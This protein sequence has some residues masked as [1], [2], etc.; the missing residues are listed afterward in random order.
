MV[1]LHDET[2]AR[3]EQ[4]DPEKFIGRVLYGALREKIKLSYTVICVYT[5]IMNSLP[6]AVS[7]RLEQSPPG[8]PSDVTRLR[9]LFKHMRACITDAHEIIQ[10]DVQTISISNYTPESYILHTVWDIRRY[11]HHIE[12]WARAIES[13]KRVNEATFAE[14]NGN[15][16]GDIA[17]D[18]LKH[19]L[20]VTQILDFAQEYA[21]KLAG[22][23]QTA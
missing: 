11:I 9:D 18:I 3:W 12:E 13:D 20:E 17:G 6:A 5:Q 8:L 7:L 22:I 23:Q 15:R 19:V 4:L 2:R 14:L 21:E 10:C 1:V 16:T